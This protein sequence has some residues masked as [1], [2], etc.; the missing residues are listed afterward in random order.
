MSDKELV[1]EGEVEDLEKLQ[2]EIARMEAE[3]A[4]IAQETEDLERQKSPSTS[5]A[6]SKGKIDLAGSSNENIKRMGKTMNCNL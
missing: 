4:R 5:L 6:A 3:A 1:E 2:A